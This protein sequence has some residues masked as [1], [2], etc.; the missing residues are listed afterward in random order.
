MQGENRECD[1]VLSDWHLILHRPCDL[2]PRGQT[3]AQYAPEHE[4]SRPLTGSGGLS[5]QSCHCLLD[6]F[7]ILYHCLNCNQLA[8]GPEVNLR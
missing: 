8:I 4:T 1:Q 7:W 2:Y 3:A 6:L 5:P